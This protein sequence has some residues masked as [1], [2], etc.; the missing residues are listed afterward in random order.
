[1]FIELFFNTKNCRKSQ[2]DIILG[3]NIFMYVRMSML[4]SNK[5]Y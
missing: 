4:N 5:Y 2:M 1:M 3:E